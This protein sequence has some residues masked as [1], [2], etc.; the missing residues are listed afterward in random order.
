MSFSLTT[1][2]WS[3]ISKI[4]I[5]EVKRLQALG[6]A[7]GAALIEGDVEVIITAL[8]A[9]GQRYN[10]AGMQAMRAERYR[11]ST[12]DEM[13]VLEREDEAAEA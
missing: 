2:R 12:L 10:I 13:K 4:L 6:D 8:K 1:C 5:R 7:S 11:K 3:F 9:F